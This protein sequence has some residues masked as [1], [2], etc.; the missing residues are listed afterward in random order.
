MENKKLNRSLSCRYT[1]G[2]VAQ[3]RAGIEV[4]NIPRQPGLEW[5]QHHLGGIMNGVIMNGVN[6]DEHI[7]NFERFQ[8]RAGQS[9][10]F[11]FFLLHLQ[12][13][14]LLSYGVNVT[15][16]NGQVSTILPFQLLDS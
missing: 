6:V 13:D 11:E 2:V 12:V 4:L 8:E 9:L 10:D 3:Q 15:V 16:Y 5:L 14:E 7:S 1:G